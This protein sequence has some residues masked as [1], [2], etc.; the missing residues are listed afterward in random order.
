MDNEDP[1][2]LAIL[3]HAS[4]IFADLD[5]G[6]LLIEKCLAIDPD[7]PLAWQRRGWLGVYRGGGGALADFDRALALNPQGPERFNTFLGMSQAHFLAGN[8][9]AAAKWAAQ[10]LRERPHE[11]WAQRVAAVA[12]VRCGQVPQDDRELRCYSGSIPTSLWAP[13]SMPYRQC[14]RS[15]LPDKP[16]RWNRQVC[17]SSPS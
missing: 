17:Q 15:S 14:R 8:Y 1:L 11:T 10:G 4:T 2:V 16:R 12:L 9:E 5:L 7:C 13:S 3:G 6:S